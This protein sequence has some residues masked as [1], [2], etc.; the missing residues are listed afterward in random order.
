VWLLGASTDFLV[1][2]LGGDPMARQEEVTEEEVRDIIATQIDVTPEQREILAGAFEVAERVLREVVVPRGQVSAIEA[3]TPVV[4]AV[5]TLVRS[6]HSRAPVYAGDMDD[7]LGVVHL[8]DLLDADGTA[9]DHVRTMTVLPETVGVLDGLRRLRAE[10]QRMA[11][12]V[13]EHGGTEGIV[14][15]EDLLE[16]IVGDLYDEFDPDLESVE[17]DD[18]GGLVLPGDYPLHD[19]PDVGIELPEGP[20]ATVAGYVLSRLGAIA[21][22][23]EVVEADG[24]RVEVLGT[25]GRAIKKVRIVPLPRA[26]GAETDEDED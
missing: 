17:R 4:T 1:K 8:R 9:A 22:G 2:L 20:Y 12:V 3:E 14:T 26:E 18:E 5:E 16:E 7:V 11:L 15:I 6:G 13:N 19:L 10:R 24:Y 25:E 23:G 21:E